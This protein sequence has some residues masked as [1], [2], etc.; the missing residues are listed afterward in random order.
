MREPDESWP[1]PDESWFE[2]EPLIEALFAWLDEELEDGV[3]IQV[4]GRAAMLVKVKGPDGKLHPATTMGDL[5]LKPWAMPLWPMEQAWPGGFLPT[6]HLQAAAEA[7]G[8][9]NLEFGFEEADD[10]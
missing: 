8:I 2:R 9:E 5:R 4:K 3:S 6:Q 1:A 10:E 7:F